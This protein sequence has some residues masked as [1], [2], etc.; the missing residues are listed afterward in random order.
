MGDSQ[1]DSGVR[2]SGRIGASLS[3]LHSSAWCERPDNYAEKAVALVCFGHGSVCAVVSVLPFPRE[4]E[5]CL[6]PGFGESS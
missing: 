5:V 1:L 3:R 2:E 4:E 6:G